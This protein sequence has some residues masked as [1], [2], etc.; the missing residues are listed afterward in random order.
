MLTR[1]TL[2][3]P[4]RHDQEILRGGNGTPLLWLHGIGGIRSDDPFVT[5]LAERYQVI[6]P[7][8]PGFND[9]GEIAEMRSIHDLILYYDDL[10]EA[11]DL[12]R[13]ILVGHS[14]GGM[15]AAEIAAHFPRRADH[16]VLLSPLG[17]WNDA[18]PVT[19]L[20]ARPDF[21]I[22]AVLWQG[23]RNR[24][25]PAE[26]AQPETRD[27]MIEHAVRLAQG[28][29][30]VCKFTWPIPDKGLGRRLY[31]ITAPTLIV[32]GEAD[33]FVPARYAADFAQLIAGSRRTVLTQA[34]HMLPYE[35]PEEILDL[36]ESF[37]RE[38]NQ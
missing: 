16:L 28:L 10:L 4:G 32:F 36:I 6:A 2:R 5:R 25:D 27:A 8:A 38:G 13:T 14:I 7:V 21:E 12:E 24:P 18:Y 37:V 3:L 17:L 15:V 29:T 35:R 23:A 22:D 26:T 1:E 33:A 30:A 9:L 20:F 11:L 19:D 34:S 31:R